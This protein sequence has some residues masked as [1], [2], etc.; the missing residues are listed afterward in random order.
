MT[1]KICKQCGKNIS[2]KAKICP[3]CGER[4]KK[5]RA[6]LK[7]LGVIVLFFVFLGLIG[8]LIEEDSTEKKT[9]RFPPDPKEKIKKEGRKPI[10]QPEKLIM[11]KYSVLDEDIYDAP[12]KTQVELNILVSGEISEIGLKVL[13]NKLYSLTKAK[14]GFKYHNSP[15]NIYIY[16]FTSKERAESGM[17]QWIAMLQKSYGDVSPKIS[18]NERQIAQLGAEPEEKF[19]L[20]EATRKQIWSEIVKA[21]DRAT[22]EAEERYPTDPT[23]SLRVGQLFELSKETPLMPELEPTDPMA[24]LQRMRRLP[25]RTTIKVLKVSTK[26]FNQWY[27]VEARSP[28]ISSLSTGWINGTALRWQGQVDPKQQLEKQGELENRLIDKYK[29]ELAKKYGLTLEQLKEIALEGVTK[30]WPFPK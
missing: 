16:A 11:P 24:A 29:N 12:I 1:L 15:T 9:D 21:E 28:S 25:P 7:L 27:F 2:T 8:C 18:V 10:I 5:S 26:H 17:G 6:F 20:S 13:L 23:Q 3:N 4:V 19:G 14:K 30:D 22:K